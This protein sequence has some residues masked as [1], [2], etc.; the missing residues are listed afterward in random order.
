MKDDEAIIKAVGAAYQQ[1]GFAAVE[2]RLND[3]QRALDH[4][5]ASLPPLETCGEETV[6]HTPSLPA[7]LLVSAE[8]AN[9]HAA[10]HKLVW[11]PTPYTG[12]AMMLG[13]YA[14]EKGQWA[15]AMAALRRGLALDPTSPALATEAALS[16]ARQGRNDEALALCDGI[17][18]ANKVLTSAE[19]ARLE[20]TRGFSLEELRRFDEAEAAYKRSLELEPQN[21]VAL[22]ELVYIQHQRAGAPPTQIQMTLG[23]TRQ[24]GAATP[25]PVAP[26]PLQQP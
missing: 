4:A 7:F 20:R 10:I 6:L 18:A 16:L 13:S 11:R 1:G 26:P 24:P 12:A 3:L 5:P 15:Q 8:A 25:P 17:L 9:S 2:P 14:N 22:N 21:P 19:R 23:H